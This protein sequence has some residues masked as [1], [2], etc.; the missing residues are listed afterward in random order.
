MRV[1]LLGF[2]NVA[3]K[4]VEILTV[5]RHEF[6]A[7]EGLD[8]DFTG[9]FTRSRGSLAGAIDAGAA[10]QE[11]RAHG[12]LS[13]SN[14][15]YSS[16]N[17]LEA[18]RTLDYDVLVELTVLSIREHG[19]PALSHVREALRRGGHVVTANKAPIAFAYDELAA[20]ARRRNVRLLHES[21]VMDGAPVFSLARSS[22][23]GCTIRGLSGILNS[24]TNF[25]LNEM[26]RGVALETAVRTAQA[27]GFAEAD[28]AHDLEGWDA[29]A[30][31][32]VLANALMGASQTP[33]DVEREGVTA[34]TPA[35]IRS[36][37]QAG[38]RLK[39]VC[40]AWREAT[41]VRTRVG[42]EEVALDHPFAT[43]SANGSV[44]RL[45]TDLMGP[46]VVAQ[47]E[48]TLYDT[49]YGVLNDLLT[50]AGRDSG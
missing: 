1:L 47:E 39:L 19:E 2:G 46:L 20:L 8:L 41:G 3:Q 22:L 14:P 18:V 23:R 12:R 24:T 44:L 49:A 5:E 29:A 50:V 33:F 36:V 6:P 26:E 42:L 21:T 10:L 4:L 30:K 34:V 17:A 15:L 13:P 37:L 40:R 31:I 16:L 48:P 9:I 7:L 32:T 43:L 27:E 38:K 11:I 25:V 45:E 28:P 35:R